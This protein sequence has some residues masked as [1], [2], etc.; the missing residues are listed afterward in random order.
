M[1]KL[2]K[3]IIDVLQTRIIILSSFIVFI[4]GLVILGANRL[5]W[6]TTSQFM[7][8]FKKT[9]I[10]FVVQ[11]LTIVS[12]SVLVVLIVDSLWKQYSNSRE[13]KIN[14]KKTIEEKENKNNVIKKREEKECKQKVI[15]Y[16]ESA[17]QDEIE[18]LSY[19]IT[20]GRRVFVAE[21][22]NKRLITLSSQGI[23]IDAPNGKDHKF[24][25]WPFQIHDDYWKYLIANKD[26]YIYED[27]NEISNPFHPYSGIWKN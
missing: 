22:D 15:D 1:I 26:K 17:P 24:L 23:I 2:V 20:S 27:A 3:D 18:I 19:C 7:L 25:Y 10:I 6:L 5:D 14:R 21:R 16:F 9:E 8:G 12:F 11:L 4:S 13:N